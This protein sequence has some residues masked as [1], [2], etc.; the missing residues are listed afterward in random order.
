MAR[1]FRTRGIKAN[2]SYEVNELRRPTI[3]GLRLNRTQQGLR[4]V[5]LSK[6][7]RLW[8]QDYPKGSELLQ[9]LRPVGPI[10]NC[11]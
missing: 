8:L 4:L 3:A 9:S 2:K 6:K 1:R 5:P 10:K 11:L 7:K